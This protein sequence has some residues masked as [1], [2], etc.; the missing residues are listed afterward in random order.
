MEPDNQ[1]QALDDDYQMDNQLDD[2][3]QQFSEPEQIMENVSHTVSGARVK[4]QGFKVPQAQE[5][6][7]GKKAKAKQDKLN[8]A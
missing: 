1:L 5:K 2:Y 6:P 4:D 3:Q 8:K 7:I